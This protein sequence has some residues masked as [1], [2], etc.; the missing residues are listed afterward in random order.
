MRTILEKLHGPGIF[1]VIRKHIEKCVRGK[2]LE[3]LLVVLFQT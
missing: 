3:S 2:E 1:E